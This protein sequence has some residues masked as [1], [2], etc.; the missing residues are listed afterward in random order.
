ME[1]LAIFILVFLIVT[2]VH[3]FFHVQEIR[4]DYYQYGWG[5]FSTF[6]KEYSK[7]LPWS[8]NG[9]SF[10]SKDNRCRFNSSDISFDGK[11]MILGYFAYLKFRVWFLKMRY[12]QRK[13]PTVKW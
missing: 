4:E 12:A 2:G 7:R 10:Y 11:G 9:Y 13:K 1:Q 5:S 6:K 3:W 8:Y